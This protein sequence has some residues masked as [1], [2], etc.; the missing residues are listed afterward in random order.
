[1]AARSS[2]RSESR[3]LRMMILIADHTQHNG[4]VGGRA[5]EASDVER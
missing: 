5:D 2:F 3:R 4:V 1:M